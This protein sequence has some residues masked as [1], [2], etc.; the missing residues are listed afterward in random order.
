MTGVFV[1]QDVYSGCHGKARFCAWFIH[2][3]FSQ[4]GF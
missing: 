1:R 2:C 4:P 3:G